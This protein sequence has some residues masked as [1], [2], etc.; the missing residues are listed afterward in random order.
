MCQKTVSNN[1]LWLRY[2]FRYGLVDLNTVSTLKVDLGS[3]KVGDPCC[4]VSTRVLQSWSSRAT[5]LH[6][7]SFETGVLE[8]VPG[9]FGPAEMI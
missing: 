4:R 9:L 6:V 2:G 5:V 1:K 3:K 8:R 7:H